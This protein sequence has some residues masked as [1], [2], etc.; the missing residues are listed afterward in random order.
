M[1]GA[2][3]SSTIGPIV[4]G[5]TKCPSPTSKWK[6]RAPARS[7]TSICSPSRAKSAAYSDGSTSTV[8]IQLIPGHGAILRPDK[9]QTLSRATKKPDVPWRCG[10]V[11]RNSRRFGWR[12]CGH[13]APRSSGSRPEASTIASF[14]SAFSVQ[15]EKSDRP[16]RLHALRGRAEQ[17]ELELRQRLRAPA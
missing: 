10:V 4:T 16:A 1:S 5:S 7:S 3:D 11:S 9:C 14:S 17:R 13:S 15:T 2:I 6:T 12:N 8:R